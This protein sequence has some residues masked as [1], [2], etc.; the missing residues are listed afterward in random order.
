MA[1]RATL[2]RILH[3]IDRKGYKAYKDIEGTYRFPGF[4]LIVDHV[5]GDPFASPSRVRVVVTHQRAGFDE[6]LYANPSRTVALRD[7]LTR[8][9]HGAVRRIAKG[10]RGIGKSGLIG[11]DVP[12]QEILD[13]SSAWITEEG[14]EVRFVMGLPASGRT[15]LGREAAAMFF[16]EVPKIV[17][18]ALLMKNLDRKAVETHVRTAEDQD[19]L[20]AQLEEKGLVAFIPDGAVLPRKSGVDDRPLVAE[21]E[22]GGGAA[23]FQSP[24][25]LK[26]TLHRPNGGPISGL[27]I[28]RGVTLIVGGGFHGKSTLLRAVERSVYNHVPG[29]GRE[30][31]VTVPS[32]VK[33]K[34][35][36]GRSVRKVDIS[37][38]IR[39][40]PFDRN[41]DAFS[42]ENASG[43]TS[44]AA[45]IMEA[46]EMGAELLLVDE[47]TSAT[48]FMIRDERMQALVAR[49]KE[50]ITPLVD[51]VRRLY[52]DMGVSVILVMGGSG[53]YFDVA[54]RVLMMDG[55]RP[56]DVTDEVRAVR[57]RFP[58]KRKNEGGESFGTVAKRVPEKES[59][60]AQRGKRDVKI[61]TKGLR[62]IR[63][64]V[65]DID[66][67]HLEQLVDVGQTRAIGAII[68]YY[69]TRYGDDGL[70]LE[71]GLERAFQDLREKGLDLLDPRKAGNLAVPRI[72][73]AAA[74]VNRMRSLKIR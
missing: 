9:F 17:D 57:E 32:A 36:D 63:Y 44:Q 28:P 59:F 70:P 42:T 3:R 56:L 7:Y 27:G 31:A 41:T 6:R 47:D 30:N 69:I 23:P 53:D 58:T 45:N 64:G 55:Y 8:T 52:D 16:E 14:V 2:E 37:P 43:S 51:K 54:D 18:S 12:G 29:D 61:D 40:L 66:L 15:V 49:E 60:K 33:I 71:E 21:G 73:E 10:S 68:H 26:V 24:E 25:S 65:T 13:R 67:T 39:N 62:H 22:Q 4:T 50:P 11:V 48:N 74:A 34:A 5:Q 72:M 19:A 46:L 20:R 35:E 1:D 38:F